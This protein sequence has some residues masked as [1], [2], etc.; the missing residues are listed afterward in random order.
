MVTT[1]VKKGQPGALYFDK[2]SISEFLSHWNIECEDF[3]LTGP[4]KCQDYQT[5]EIKDRIGRK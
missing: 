2:F 4:Q 3:G 5:P 1:V